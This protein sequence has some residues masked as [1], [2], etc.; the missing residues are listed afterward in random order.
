MLE[1]SA[2]HEEENFDSWEQCERLT[3]DTCPIPKGRLVLCSRN[4]KLSVCQGADL[5]HLPEAIIYIRSLGL[6]DRPA[7]VLVPQEGLMVVHPDGVDGHAS[8]SKA[9]AKIPEL[10][11]ID[12][13]NLESCLEKFHVLETL[14]P[15]GLG[16]VW[17]NAKDRLVERNAERSIRDNLF[18][19]LRWQ[20]FQDRRVIREHQQPN[21]R[22]D[23][24]IYGDPDDWGDDKLIELKILRS[25]PS[26]W[27]KGKS[28]D[29]PDSQSIKYVQ[30]GIAQTARYRDVTGVRHA[31]LCCFDARLEN[32]DLGLFDKAD[33]AGI[34]LRCYYMESSTP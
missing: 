25:R 17:I 29:H 1:S 18:K 5:V 13:G 20:V 19:F 2:L 34:I 24:F 27:I 32:N 14:Y 12:T 8:E 15:S 11:D 21:G 30:R 26:T 16:C 33:D 10:A 22:I 3:E 9:L 28:K 23:I 4:L 31:Y 7:V 6:G